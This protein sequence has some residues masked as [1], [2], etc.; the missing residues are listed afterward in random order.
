[1]TMT[2]LKWLL[3]MLTLS[4][5]LSKNSLAA[6]YYVYSFSETH[7]EVREFASSSDVSIYVIEI[8]AYNAW[9]NGIRSNGGVIVFH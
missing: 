9:A 5:I 6:D 1:M 4:L 7:Y 3:M 2:R 8:N